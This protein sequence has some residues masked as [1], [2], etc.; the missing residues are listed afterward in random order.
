VYFK[1]LAKLEYTCN[2]ENN[3]QT[4]GISTFLIAQRAVKSR[5]IANLLKIIKNTEFFSSLKGRG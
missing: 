1:E 2:S 3:F 4:I 5:I